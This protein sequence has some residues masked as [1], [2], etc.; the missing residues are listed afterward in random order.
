MKIFL[1]LYILSLYCLLACI[2]LIVDLLNLFH[3]PITI[4]IKK[5]E[6]KISTLLDINCILKTFFK[7]ILTI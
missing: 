7:L 4:F 2:L 5:N 6:L 1:K 3:F